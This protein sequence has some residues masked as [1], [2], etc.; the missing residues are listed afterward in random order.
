MVNARHALDNP[1]SKDSK[2]GLRRPQA[3][4]QLSNVELSTTSRGCRPSTTWLFQQLGLWAGTL[5]A[6]AS[7][8][9]VGG[10]DA[11]NEGQSAARSPRRVVTSVRTRLHA[12][13]ALFPV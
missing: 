4:L 8:E 12:C 13:Y 2:W 7:A 10:V 11:A 9:G 3:G 1:R 5:C 6:S